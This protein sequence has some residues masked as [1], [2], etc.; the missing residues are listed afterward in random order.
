MRSPFG[1]VGVFKN[2]GDALRRFMASLRAGYN[3]ELDFNVVG[4]DA[5]I[6]PLPFTHAEIGALECEAAIENAGITL[7]G[8][9][10]GRSDLLRIALDGEVTGHLVLPAA[11]VFD[12]VRRESGQRMSGQCKPLLLFELRIGFG[13]TGVNA[14]QSHLDGDLGLFRLGRIK[15][16][17]GGLELAELSVHLHVHLAIAEREAAGGSVER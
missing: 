8:K 14:G 5:E 6:L 1:S 2:S 12:L 4:N 9:G 3:V 10:E 7:L 17:F 16:Q 11:E 13:V 15:T